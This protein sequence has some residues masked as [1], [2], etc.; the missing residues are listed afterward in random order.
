MFNTD[1]FGHATI[2]WRLYLINVNDS[3]AGILAVGDDAEVNEIICRVPM[4]SKGVDG[5][6]PTAQKG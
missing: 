4:S 1:I 3:P 5:I 6:N 2:E